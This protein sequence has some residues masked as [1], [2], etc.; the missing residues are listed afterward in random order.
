MKKLAL[1]IASIL[2]AYKRKTSATP[3]QSCMTDALRKN[4]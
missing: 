1:V 2:A 3:D 4:I